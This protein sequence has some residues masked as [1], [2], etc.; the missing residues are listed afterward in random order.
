[1]TLDFS[2]ANYPLMILDLSNT[3]SGPE[4]TPVFRLKIEDTFS[5]YKYLMLC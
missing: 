1:M 2:N 3:N 5:V 4:S